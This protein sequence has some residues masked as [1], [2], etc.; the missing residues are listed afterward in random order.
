MLTRRFALPIAA[1]TALATVPLLAGAAPAGASGLAAKPGIASRGDRP[2]DP[3]GPDK[4]AEEPQNNC[5]TTL[6]TIPLEIKGLA[7][8]LLLPKPEK[9]REDGSGGGGGGGLLG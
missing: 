2:G 9:Q 6:W 5:P 8:I 1:L 4:R 3:K 7:C